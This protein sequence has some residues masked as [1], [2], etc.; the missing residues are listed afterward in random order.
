MQD[1]DAS[2][3]RK[4]NGSGMA[5]RAR[6]RHEKANLIRNQS[7]N[8]D[9][10]RRDNCVRKLEIKNFKKSVFLTLPAKTPDALRGDKYHSKRTLPL[11]QVNY[12]T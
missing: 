10:F 1:T 11:T 5:A 8:E 4:Y 12:F 2:E 9:M 6:Y 7:D 3:E